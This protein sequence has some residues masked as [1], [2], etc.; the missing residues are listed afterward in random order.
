MSGIVGMASRDGSP[1]DGE[2]IRRLT[3][4][5]SFRGPDAQVVWADGPA[6]LGHALLRLTPADVDE[7]QPCSLDGRTWIAAEARLDGRDEL[8]SRLVERGHALHEVADGIH[9]PNDRFTDARLILAAYREWGE[10]CVDYLA[11]D[12]VFA[13][14]DGDNRQ[15]FCARDQFGVRPFYYCERGTTLLFSNTLVCLRQHRDIGRSIDEKWLGDW[16][17]FDYCGDTGRTAFADIQRLPAAH[18]LTYSRKGLRIRRYWALPTEHPLLRLGSEEAYVEEFRRLVEQ[19]LRD[20]LPTP[21]AAAFMS[22]GLDSSF[23]AGMASRYLR[24]AF[25]QCD[26]HAFTL[27]FARL[28]EDEE[29]VWA[30]RAAAG[31]DI[32]HHEMLMDDYAPFPGWNGANPMFPASEPNVIQLCGTQP[33]PVNFP[34][35]QT[36]VQF[37]RLAASTARVA[38]TGH[39]AD[40][41][42][43]WPQ[44][45]FQ[46]R[47][48]RGQIWRFLKE[49]TSYRA[50]FG[51]RPPLGLRS[52]FG[53]GRKKTP[54]TGYPKWINE[55]FAARLDLPARFQALHEPPPAV[56]TTR[57]RAHSY[58]ADSAGWSVIFEST[59]AGVTGLPLSVCH[60]L[61][62]LRIITFFLSIPPFP[63][64]VNKHLLRSASAGI[65]SEE[66][67]A[68]PKSSFP[69]D[70][71]VFAFQ[72]LD[73]PSLARYTLPEALDPFI[74]REAVPSLEALQGDRGNARAS[75]I[76]RPYS[77]AYWILQQTGSLTNSKGC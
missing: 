36:G 19:A 76:Y 49:L 74:C 65:L 4:Y 37:K 53:T 8:R 42:L 60:P 46:S 21:R 58:L 57:P 23:V 10:N 6:A 50:R 73:P 41:G 26:L 77:L 55:R 47:L 62:D 44:A 64:C 45:Y 2:L 29:H 22:G 38:L 54:V 31:M 51:R 61:F 25:G 27:A 59:D 9:Q 72:Q 43:L 71:N 35:L 75:M 63:W 70:P 15:L 40:P 28:V 14:W 39:G 69:G 17:V 48:R 32:P 20:R 56:H 33:E 1:G 12:F 18:C 52:W 68:R 11:G 30:P 66:V 7:R 16:L 67:R 13:L 5:M 34:L 3:E 24:R